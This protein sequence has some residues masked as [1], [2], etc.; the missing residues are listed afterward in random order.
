M[1]GIN[2]RALDRY[3]TTDGEAFARIEKGNPILRFELY[4]GAL[5]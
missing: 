1:G 5:P 2:G 4:L 3:A